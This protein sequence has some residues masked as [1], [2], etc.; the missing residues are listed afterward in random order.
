MTTSNVSFGLIP[1]EDW[2][3]PDW[4][5]EEKAKAGRDSLVE[6]GIIYGGE[7]PHK[8]IPCHFFA[9]LDLPTDSVTYALPHSGENAEIP[10]RFS[11]YRN[12][13]RFQSR[14]FYK[15]ELV[16]PYKWYWRVE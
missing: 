15:Q 6:Q 8:I 5:D 16:L 7:S 12:M 1:A 14:A 11:S 9:A 3:Q 13:C 10:D 2:Y 4:I